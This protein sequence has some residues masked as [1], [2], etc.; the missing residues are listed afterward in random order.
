MDLLSNF[1]LSPIW[2]RFCDKIPAFNST[3]AVHAC[4]A[5]V[6]KVEPWLQLIDHSFPED[7]AATCFHKSRKFFV[8]LVVD[9]TQTDYRIPL[10]LLLVLE[11]TSVEVLDSQTRALNLVAPCLAAEVWVNKH[12][13][14]CSSVPGTLLSILKYSG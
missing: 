13:V 5:A 12:S 1:S 14:S 8:S 2:F 3:S 7:G 10:L 6:S 4:L 11:I 9:I